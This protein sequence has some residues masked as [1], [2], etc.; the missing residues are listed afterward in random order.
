MAEAKLEIAML[1]AVVHKLEDIVKANLPCSDIEHL[2]A[3]INLLKN[4]N[5]S[6]KELLEYSQTSWDQPRQTSPRETANESSN[7]P[8]FNYF[9]PL[10]NEP[11]EYQS[12]INPS[13]QSSVTVPASFD[14][15]IEEYRNN[16]RLK[17][18]ASGT[19]NARERPALEDDNSVVE[20]SPDKSDARRSILNRSTQTIRKHKR[21]RIKSGKN[22]SHCQA[23]VKPANVGETSLEMVTQTDTD[24]ATSMTNTKKEIYIIGDSIVKNI[25]GHRLSS[26]A[27]VQL[28]DDIL[29]TCIDKETPQPQQDEI[30]VAILQ[31]AGPIVPFRAFKQSGPRK[32]R[33]VTVEEFKHSAFTC[34]NYGK[35]VS[36]RV[37]R[38]PKPSN[39]FF[40]KN[41]TTITTQWT[42]LISEETYTEKFRFHL[43]S[44]VGPGL[45]RSLVNAG[46]VN[47]DFF[48]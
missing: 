21:H 20:V 48:A 32:L 27:K 24:P 37:P 12:D 5:E 17:C 35:L 18:I 47:D 25:D 45:K 44:S 46:Q 3:E 2:K 31:I 36:V 7:T 38:Q 4:Q 1:W 28:I 11:S 14:D 43:H 33:S 30:N 19:F 22:R 41:P 16:E 9:E 26:K 10:A 15:Q 29:S 23:T 40:K 13:D 34:S 39:I 42:S 8:I 6:I